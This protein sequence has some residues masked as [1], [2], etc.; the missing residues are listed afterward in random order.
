MAMQ[1]LLP[2]LTEEAP[3]PVAQRPRRRRST[4]E[5]VR[6]ITG[7]TLMIAA[8][9]F[10]MF[11][12]WQLWWSNFDAHANQDA[13]LDELEEQWGRPLRDADTTD[14]LT[15]DEMHTG[16][17]PAIGEVPHGEIYGLVHIP[18]L[19]VDWVG[20]LAEGATP[21]VL[22][23]GMLGHIENTAQVGEYGNAGISGHRTTYGAILRD[24]EMLGDG[25]AVIVETDDNWYVYEVTLTRVVDPHDT[26][27]LAADP[28]D[29]SSTADPAVQRL[30]LTT[31]HPLWSN[32]E[33][34]IVHT[35]LTYWAYTVDG[36][37]PEMR[38]S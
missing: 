2:G 3:E 15:P 35:E 23:A 20:P 1:D 37:P 10:G 12:L 4:G 27:V 14:W 28:E 22:D 36:V 13:A 11:F 7:E 30:T 26:W 16:A 9:A 32:H 38:T 34:Y 8:W 5:W 33:R 21:D 31:C 25:D 18:V 29:P 6:I 24:I 17:A 19:G